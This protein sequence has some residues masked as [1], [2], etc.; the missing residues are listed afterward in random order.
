MAG[1]TDTAVLIIVITGIIAILIS[2]ITPS[3]AIEDE[4]LVIKLDGKAAP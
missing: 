2:V 1:V 4:Q 3:T